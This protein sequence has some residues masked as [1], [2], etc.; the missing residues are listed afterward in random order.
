[1]VYLVV[2]AVRRRFASLW[3]DF[4]ETVIFWGGGVSW[5]LVGGLG[6]GFLLGR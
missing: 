6:V 1:M 4:A 5:F 3:K 2:E